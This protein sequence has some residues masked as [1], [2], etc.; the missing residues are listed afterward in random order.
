VDNINKKN[1]IAHRRTGSENMVSDWANNLIYALSSAHKLTPR[2]KT[3]KKKW[4]MMHKLY[5]LP[6]QIPYFEI[7]SLFELVQLFY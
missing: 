7:P 6:N 4:L 2:F 5:C 3:A 1:V